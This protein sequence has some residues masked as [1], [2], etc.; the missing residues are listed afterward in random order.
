MAEDAR[1]RSAMAGLL[2]GGAVVLLPWRAWQIH[3]QIGPRAAVQAQLDAMTVRNIII[4]PEPVWFGLDFVRN[5]PYL[6][7][8]PVFYAAPEGVTITPLGNGDSA[9]VTGRD[10]I[11]M[12]LGRGTYL[13]PD[14]GP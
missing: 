9:V 7:E 1:L 8:G 13:E 6:R 12:G 3:E 11:G 2:I 5:D 4:R 14:F 10:L